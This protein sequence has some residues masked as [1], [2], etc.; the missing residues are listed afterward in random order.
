[1]VSDAD[2]FYSSPLMSSKGVLETC[3]TSDVHRSVLVMS[4]TR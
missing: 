1:M 4:R 3:S 2:P